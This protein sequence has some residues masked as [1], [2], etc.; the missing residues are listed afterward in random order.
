[1]FRKYVLLVGVVLTSLLLTGCSMNNA[2]NV[3]GDVSTPLDTVTWCVKAPDTEEYC[4]APIEFSEGDSAYISLQALDI[5]EESFSF[6]GTDY[7]DAGYFVTTVNEIPGD[8]SHFWKLFQN[9]EESQVGISQIVLN[10]D[11]VMLFEY[12]E[13]SF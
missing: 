6:D 13:I 4:Y 7:G 9:R 10:P 11:D 1:M 2:G 5:R 8:Q 12:T 3:A